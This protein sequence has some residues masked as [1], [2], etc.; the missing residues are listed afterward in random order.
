M[1]DA[2]A[3]DR[4]EV[5]LVMGDAAV[6][7]GD[8]QMHEANRL[9]QRGATWARDTGDCHREI[10]VGMF[11]RAEGHRDCYFLANRAKGLQLCCLDADHRVL[12]LIGIGD[13]AAIDYI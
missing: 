7:R 13:K 8:R 3:P 1:P 2:A 6:A 12:G 11:K 9:T 4:A 5:L 10:D